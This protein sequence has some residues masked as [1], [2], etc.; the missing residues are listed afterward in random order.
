MNV[1]F[2]ILH[3]S[4]FSLYFTF[5]LSTICF[6]IHLMLGI[7]IKAES[8]HGVSAVNDKVNV[9]EFFTSHILA[10]LQETNHSVRPMVK[11]TAIKFASTFRNQ[12][13]KEHITALMPLLIHHLSSPSVVVHTYSAAA[14]EKFLVCKDTSGTGK[15]AKFGG[16][17]LQAFLEPLFTGLFAIVDN[18]DLNENEYVMKCIM[19][20]LSS[21]RDSIIQVV[22]IV[23]EKL[24]AA[25]F[26]VAKNPRNPQYNHYLFES[27]AVLVKAVCSKNPEHVATFETLL[28]P[29]FQQVLQMDVAEFTPYV[30]Q[31]FAQLLEYR[32]ANTGLGEAYNM[33]LGPFLSPL[34]WER[35]GNIPALTR[36]LQA[37][38]MKGAAEIAASN[39][40]QGILGVFQKL[41]LEG[42]SVEPPLLLFLSGRS[43]Q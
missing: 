33:L 20:C 10:E 19:R 31:I 39:Q 24:T 30:F 7:A 11:A 4:S 14:I 43:F 29:P 3:A 1:M 35:R 32:P 23:L 6:Q 41:L 26:V 37:Y 9:M 15:V 28:F 27:I 36:L 38:L 25:L 8:N 22:Q 12:F 5:L 13:T 21:A 42:N 40:L 16:Q 2:S 18:G 34:I 17:D